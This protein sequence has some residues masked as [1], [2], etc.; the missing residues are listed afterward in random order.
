MELSEQL[1]RAVAA[2]GKSRYEIAK[3]AEI[4]YYALARFLDE[5]RDIRLS[6]V[7]KLAKLFGMRLTKPKRI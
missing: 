5:D 7:Q 6:T 3:E 2:S 1:K 4:D